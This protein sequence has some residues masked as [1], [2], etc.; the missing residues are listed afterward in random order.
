MSDA[1]YRKLFSAVLL[2]LLHLPLIAYALWLYPRLQ[3]GQNILHLPALDLVLLLA[4]LL[5]PYGLLSRL[6]PD[7][8]PARARLGEYDD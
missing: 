3:A 2:V 1:P 5:L 6:V 8:N 7:W 4:L